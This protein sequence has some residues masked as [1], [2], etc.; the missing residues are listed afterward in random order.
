MRRSLF[1]ANSSIRSAL[2]DIAGRYPVNLR[3]RSG[4]SD[5]KRVG[6]ED[7]S[8]PFAF[9]NVKISGCAVLT[10]ITLSGGVCFGTRKHQGL[11]GISGIGGGE[12]R[13]GERS[14]WMEH[15]T[16]NADHGTP[17]IECPDI[18]AVH[19]PQIFHSM[20]NVRCST[21]LPAFSQWPGCSRAPGFKANP[22]TPARSP[23]G[24]PSPP[25]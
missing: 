9:W 3:K 11:R 10:D 7:I 22:G 20:L 5:W 16:W 24:V 12:A 2:D 13:I 8:D 17:N 4:G 6:W 15:R 25:R 19:S 14:A 18:P 1:L 23:R 21:F